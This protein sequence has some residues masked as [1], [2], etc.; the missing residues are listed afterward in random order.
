MGIEPTALCLEGRCSTTE[1]RP[2]TSIIA[3]H[4]PVPWLVLEH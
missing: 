2:L 1:L 3:I 4:A